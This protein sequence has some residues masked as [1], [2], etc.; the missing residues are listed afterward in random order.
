MD[1]KDF[2]TRGIDVTCGDRNTTYGPPL[3]NM[4]CA[5]ELKAVF[6]KYEKGKGG[7]AHRNAIHLCCDKLSRIATGGGFH[8]DNYVDGAVYIA[9]AGECHI[10]N[11]TPAVSLQQQIPEPQEKPAS[12]AQ[13][14]SKLLETSSS[15]SALLETPS[16]SLPDMPSCAN[17][18]H[19]VGITPGK[20]CRVALKSSLNFSSPRECA[21]FTRLAEASA[22]N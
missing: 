10:D 11:T 14:P 16:S 2:L 6:D 18:V 15:S 17:C 5:A 3:P 20:P 21:K 1:R 9:I 22:S 7:L 19:G 13:Q 12:L 8:A 4:Q